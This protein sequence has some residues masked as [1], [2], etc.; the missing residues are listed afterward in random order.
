MMTTRFFEADSMTLP[1][2]D[3][4]NLEED[5]PST[6]RILIVDDEPGVRQSLIEVLG[7]KY[8][9]FEADSAPRAL[10]MFNEVQ[11]ETMVIDVRMPGES[12]IDLLRSIRSRSRGS[13]V[14]VILLTAYSETTVLKE[15]ISLQVNDFIEKPFDI[16]EMLQKVERNVRRADALNKP[17]RGSKNLSTLTTQLNAYLSQI[18]DLTHLNTFSLEVVHDLSSILQGISFDLDLLKASINDPTL[19]TI[20]EN[21]EEVLELCREVSRGKELLELWLS[22]IRTG[23]QK[24]DIIEIS[25]LLHDFIFGFDSTLKTHRVQLDLS[26]IEKGPFYV[27]GNEVQ[28]NR[29]I[30]NILLN[31]IQSFEKKGGAIEISCSPNGDNVEIRIRDHGK[32]IPKQQI[33][34]IFE[35]GFTTKAHSGGS[36]LGLFIVKKIME[37]CKGSIQIDSTMGEGTTVILGIPLAKKTR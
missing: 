11:P 10:A 22:I 23:T 5:K 14:P 24:V 8:E 7:G 4:E 18:N 20:D 19:S 12:G 1:A 35:Q 3:I 37:A 29:V 36:G 31:A 16:Q 9:V 26:R 27:L 30:Q 28:L 34:K 25:K 33:K 15:A 13:N 6:P 21:R 2:M 17:K 32:G